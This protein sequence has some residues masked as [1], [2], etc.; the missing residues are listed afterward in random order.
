MPF[1]IVP[2]WIILLI[3][4]YIVVSLSAGITWMS[5]L[6]KCGFRDFDFV[7][8]FLLFMVNNGPISFSTP[9]DFHKIQLTEI[10]H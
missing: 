6:A 8:N 3:Y 1:V 9:K 10:G 7:I 2:S 4:I 5:S